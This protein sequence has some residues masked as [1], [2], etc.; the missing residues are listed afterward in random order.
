MKSD[1]TVVVVIS[2]IICV[3]IVV[4]LLVSIFNPVHPYSKP[5]AA[6][7]IVSV[8]QQAESTNSTLSV[9]LEHPVLFEYKYA[10]SPFTEHIDEIRINLRAVSLITKTVM[11]N[12]NKS[13]E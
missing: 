10:P 3:N 9:D 6:Q 2:L 8:Q 7:Q 11:Q 13:K 4:S 1:R 5:T 12:I